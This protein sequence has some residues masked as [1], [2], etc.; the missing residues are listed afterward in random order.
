MVS[1]IPNLLWSSR[2]TERRLSAI[3]SAQESARMVAASAMLVHPKHWKKLPP[4]K[5]E[6]SMTTC[7]QLK[8]SSLWASWRSI[9]PNK[10]QQT[11]AMVRELSIG[12]TRLSWSLPGRSASTRRASLARL[13]TD[14][15]ARRPHCP[16][17]HPATPSARPP[18]KP[19]AWAG[20]GTTTVRTPARQSPCRSAG[21]PG[22]GH[23]QSP[24]Y[25]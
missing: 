17:Q 15:A 20:A 24:S 21:H 8:S 9:K 19:R 2:K 7:L 3:I 4:V 13:F 25:R 23:V 6:S 12:Y 11:A 22:P 14:P 5:D 16:L 10:H 18:Q 1:C